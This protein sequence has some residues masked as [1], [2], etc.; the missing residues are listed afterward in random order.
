MAPWRELPAS[1]DPQ[2]RRLV[3]QLRTLKDRGGLSL[4]ALERRTHYSRSS[5]ERYLNGKKL[6]PAD[7]VEQLAQ[8]AGGDVHRLLALHSLAEESWVRGRPRTAAPAPEPGEAA[9]APGALEGGTGRVGTGGETRA[10]AVGAVGR[11]RA[12]LPIRQALTITPC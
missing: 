2:S 11:P 9:A 10:E 4:S 5:W 6:P 7:A 1:L 12:H 3:T 8:V